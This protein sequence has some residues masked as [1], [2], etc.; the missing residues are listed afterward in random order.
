MQL[1]RPILP[2]RRVSAGKA[3]G[4][5]RGALLVMRTVA[6]VA[7][8]LTAV[9]LPASAEGDGPPDWDD[10]SV[11]FVRR[12]NMCHSE[13]GASRGL[14]LD[15]YAAALAGSQKGVV[16]LPG[17]P[18]A[19]ELMLRLRGQRTPR[20]PFLGPPLPQDEIDVIERWIAAGLPETSL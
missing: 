16:L 14:R 7:V 3:A 19:S 6:L 5:G 9:A 1:D 8:V 20:M 12:C 4:I 18:D 2:Q 15:S 17:D 11:I 13:L 10:A